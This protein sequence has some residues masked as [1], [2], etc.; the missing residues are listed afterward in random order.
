MGWSLFGG[1]EWEANPGL[2]DATKYGEEAMS[3]SDNQKSAGNRF[4][5]NILR[6][7]MSGDTSAIG[8]PFLKVAA[9]R[10]RAYQGN[11][12]DNEHI[13]DAKEFLHNNMVDEQAGGQ[14]EDYVRGNAMGAAQLSSSNANAK[15]QRHADIAANLM[16]AALEG[17]QQ[18]EQKSIFGAVGAGLDLLSKFGAPT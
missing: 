2:D 9:A 1:T 18:V 7:L 10:K 15:A 6:G 13:A 8:N 14:F 12:Y 16:R 5:R 4:A 11:P 3:Y 17:H